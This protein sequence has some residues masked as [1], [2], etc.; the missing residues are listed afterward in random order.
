[1]GAY[2]H[3]FRDKVGGQK[4]ILNSLVNR[5]DEFGIKLYF[6]E[7]ERLNE[8]LLHEKVYWKQRAKTFW[9]QEGDSNSKYFHAQASQRKRLNKIPYLLNDAGEKVENAEEMM[10]LTR[11]YFSNVFTESGRSELIEQTVNQ[12]IISTCQNEKLVADLTFEEFTRAVKQMHP[13]KA[14]G[15][16]GFSPAFFQHFWGLIGI[17]VFNCCREWLENNSFPVDLN[18]TNLILIPKKENVEKLSDIRPIAL[19]NVLYKILAKVLANRLKLI[20]P[21]TISENQS[22]FVPGRRITDNVLIAFEMIHFM[23]GKKGSQVGEVALKLD[24][25]KA[26]DRVCWKYLWYMIKSMGFSDK[27]VRWMKLC[28]TIVQYNVCLNG[29]MAGPI[30]PRR[31]LKQGDPISPYLFLL[32][33]EGLSK[34]LEIKANSGEIN[35]CRISSNA[36]AIIHLLFADDS[37]LF[38][39]AT[40]QE[41]ITIKS[42]LNDYET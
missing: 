9:L 31:G 3:K 2:I 11:E 17:E 13:D 12:I 41:A 20:L 42:V 4:L 8:L 34:A 26:Y 40:E 5:E 33:A 32:C 23:R 25:S 30:I 38:F 39:Q 22:A 21:F 29:N 1:M 15:P 19:C 27:W 7:R 18:D 16:D 6:K 24:I 10:L 14:S 28:V 37:F 36:P 35:G